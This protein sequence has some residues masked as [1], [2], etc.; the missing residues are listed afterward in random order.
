MTENAARP[1][2]S[3]EIGI[4]FECSKGAGIVFWG[5]TKAL[6]FKTLAEA[7][8]AAPLVKSWVEAGCRGDENAIVYGIWQQVY[9]G[10]PQEVP[11]LPV[12]A[13]RPIDEDE[14]E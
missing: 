3:N 1:A 14:E 7:A 4:P 2:R 10:K 9:N 5:P 11:F 8:Q 12:E 6:L 13:Y